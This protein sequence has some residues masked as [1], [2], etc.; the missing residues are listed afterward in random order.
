MKKIRCKDCNFCKNTGINKST[1]N[2]VTGYSRK[3]YMCSNPKARELPESAFGN[4]MPCFIGFGDCSRES[5]IQIKT[6]P[7]WCPRKDN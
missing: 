1:A 6:A 7:K 3:K 5:P 2:S 4:S